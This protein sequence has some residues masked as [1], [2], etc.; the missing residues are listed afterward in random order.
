MSISA[1]GE[2]DIFKRVMALVLDVNLAKPIK[3]D[4]LAN[5]QTPTSDEKSLFSN[6]LSYYQILL[7]KVRQIFTILLS[8]QCGI[9]R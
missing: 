7:L 5:S 6:N 4:Y 9:L 8:S 1:D 3:E 2:S